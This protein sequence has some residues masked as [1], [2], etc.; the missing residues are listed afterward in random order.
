MARDF[1]V[2]IDVG[3]DTK[4]ATKNL[5]KLEKQFGLTR[6][7]ML[8]MGAAAVALGAALAIGIGKAISKASEFE[9]TQAKFLTVF[10]DVDKEAENMASNLVENFGLSELAAK[11]LLAATG[12]LLTGFNF[13]GKQALDMASKVNTLAVDLAS[14]SNATGGAEAVSNA[15]TKALLGEREAL[16][17]YGIAIIEADIKAELL[18]RGMGK[19]TGEA[20]RQ[21]KAQITLDLAYRQSRKAVGDFERTQT[22]FANQTRIA[23]ASIEDIVVTIGQNFLPIATKIVSTFNT[24]MI[25]VIKNVV[26]LFGDYKLVIGDTAKELAGLDKPMK[27]TVNLSNIISSNF[28]AMGVVFSKVNDLIRAKADKIR[29]EQQAIADQQTENNQQMLES[30]V[31][32]WEN[33]V[34]QTN[35]STDM[36]KEID[37]GLFDYRIGLLDNYNLKQSESIQKQIEQETKRAK[38]LKELHKNVNNAMSAGFATAVKNSIDEGWN[39]DKAMT[40]IA[41]S[42]RDVYIDMASK[43]AAEWVMK[44]GVMQAA[45]LAWKGLEIAAMAVV[46]AGAAAV[47][48][49]KTI[50]FPFNFAVAAGAA[51]GAKEL[52]NSFATGIRGFEGGNAIVGEHGREMIKVPVGASVLNNAE[53]ENIL[54]RGTSGLNKVINLNVSFSNNN[55]LGDKDD[56]LSFITDGM[57]S[58]LRLQANV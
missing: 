6:N 2:G 24:K 38:I 33:I 8:A 3:A 7:Q 34:F 9:E 17:T 27:N 1:K 4:N 55:F 47:S 12:D 42:I 30:S 41:T 15:L 21:A 20:L 32:T 31:L 52:I 10:E 51:I 40:T 56:M 22:S 57:M 28:K 49:F 16:K 25:P 58:E 11:T 39:M 37:L 19:L 53:T 43:I 14:F 36:L 50:P 23:K 48:V 45:T 26:D 44:Q 46:A 54:S 18:A 29:E 5:S 35:E 13:T